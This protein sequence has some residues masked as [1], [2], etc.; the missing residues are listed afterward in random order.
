MTPKRSTSVL[1]GQRSPAGFED[2]L[3]ILSASDP[4]N[5]LNGKTYRPCLN[6]QLKRCLGP[7]RGTFMWKIMTKRCSRFDCSCGGIMNVGTDQKPDEGCIGKPE[8]EKAAMLR[9]QA[10]ALGRILKNRRFWMQRK[11]SGCIQPFP[12]VQ[13]R[14]YSGFVHPKRQAG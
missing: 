14:R 5:G 9:D 2:G 12:R 11:R 10:R 7:C 13:Q 1:S 3:P 6:Y 4:E 8:F